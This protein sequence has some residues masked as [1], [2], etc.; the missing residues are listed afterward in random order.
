VFARTNDRE[1]R[2]R[3]DQEERQP[4]FFNRHMLPTFRDQDQQGAW[5]LGKAVPF[6]FEYLA[7]ASFRE[8]NFGEYADDA[9]KFT[10]AGRSEARQGFVICKRCGKVQAPRRGQQTLGTE[11]A[12]EHTIGCPARQRRE[13]ESDFQ[14]AVYLYRE[15]SSEAVRLLLP[16]ADVGSDRRLHSFV[17]AFQVGLKDRYGGRVD[18]LHTLV[19]SEPERD[20]QLR[21]QYL[22]LYDGVP[23][24]TGYLKDLMREPS[25]GEEHALLGVLRRARD[26][27][28]SCECFGDP[29]RDGCYRCLF[30][31][32]NSRDMSETSAHEALAMLTE[33]LDQA[34]TLVR[35]ESL[36]EIKVTGLMDS[37]LEARFV[38]ALQRFARPGLAVT[39]RKSL[40]RNK[41]GFQLSVGSQ[42]WLIEP[43]VALGAAQGLA[44][45]VSID[46]VLRPAKVASARKPIAVFL[47][48]FQ[49]HRNQVGD[50]MLR[51][52]ALL[53]GGEYDVWGFTWDDINAAFDRTTTLPPMQL[54]PDGAMLKSWYQQLGLGAWTHVLDTTPMELFMRSLASEKEEIPWETLAAIT[55]VAQMKLPPQ[56]DV[57]AWKAEIATWVPAPFRSSFEVDEQWLFARRPPGTPGTLALWATASRAAAKD[58][59]LIDEFRAVVWLDDASEHHDTPAYHGAWRGFLFAFLLLRRLPHVLFLTRRGSKQPDG[60]AALAHLR[61]ASSKNL[62]E[63]WAVLDVGPDFLPICEQLAAAQVDLPEVGFDLPDARGLSS[64]VEGELVWESLR[65]AVVRELS[66]SMKAQIA[67]D[68]TVFELVACAADTTPLVRALRGAP[69]GDPT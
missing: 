48:G 14:A 49:F 67:P 22:V 46:F 23:G 43:Q 12:G 44:V 26:R 13:K 68:W 51:R 39:V 10:I 33:I 36:S 31:Y 62:D 52:M 8:I 50:D 40:V 32:R 63:A 38:E 65:V 64:G 11:V 55:L 6:A 54:N 34:E 37:V 45:G 17:A 66:E 24:G 15:F 19:Y 16:L 53:S 61:M 20:S 9:T 56:V 2:I 58:V 4:R 21:R 25:A 7:R 5:R 35:T 59:T 69:Q 29:A 1:S 30:A 42:E 18:H 47:D 41:P 27:I 57:A 3:D 28:R 60:F